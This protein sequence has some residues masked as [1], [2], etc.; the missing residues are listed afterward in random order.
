MDYIKLL[1]LILIFFLVIV[2]IVFILRKYPVIVPYTIIDK[3]DKRYIFILSVLYSGISF[4]YFGQINNFGSW[5]GNFPQQSFQIKLSEPVVIGKVYYYYGLGNGNLNLDY[6]TMDKESGSIRFNNEWSAYKWQSVA[7]PLT[8]PITELKISVDTP[9]VDLKQLALFDNHGELV[10]N[11]A[12]LESGSQTNNFSTIMASKLPKNYDNNLLSSTFF[13]EVYYARTAYEYLHGLS[14]Y[15][16][17]HPPLGMLLIAIGIIIFGMNPV[18]WRIIPNLT[19]VIMIGV[20]Y[21]L[22]KRLFNSRKAAIISS[23]LLMFDC[24]HFTMSRMA[25]IDS[26]MTLFIVCEYYFLLGYLQNTLTGRSNQAVRSLLWCGFFLGLAAATKWE[27]VYTVPLILLCLV[28]CELIYKKPSL[29]HFILTTGRCIVL[30][31]II[32]IA[33]YLL[34]YCSYFMHDPAQ[35]IFNFVLHLQ[36][37]MWDYHS[38]YALNVTHPYA[39]NWWSWP[40]LVKPLSLYYWQNNSGLASSV[41]LIGNPA[42]WWGGLLAVIGILFYATREKDYIA[43]VIVLM[44]ASLYLPWIFVGRLSFIYYFYAVTPF[45]ILAIAYILKRFIRQ[46]LEVVYL[47]MMLV[48]VLF[49]TFYPVISGIPFSRAYVLKYLWWLP[50][51]NF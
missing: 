46:N 24:M 51:W 7:I 20:I 44:I 45:W 2:I 26:S 29:K 14:P 43:W 21:L 16:W 37:A 49:V 36:K 11:F 50:G 4:F 9:Q 27:G 35:N 25:S 48:I 1:Q 12:L 17:V 5:Q 22:A 40:L 3:L 15:S 18:G 38:S 28:Y 41:V 23:V 47:Y 34:S 30:L 6:L 19:G 42:I 32:P 13:D 39:S 8:K 31:V 10:S 33:I